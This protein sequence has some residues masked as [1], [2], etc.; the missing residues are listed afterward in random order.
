MTKRTDIHSTGKINPADYLNIGWDYVGPDALEMMGFRG[1]RD[2][3]KKVMA[4]NNWTWSL[5]T[6]G[7][8]CGICGAL[9]HYLGIFVHTHTGEVIRVGSTCSEKMELEDLGVFKAARA[10]I[11]LGREFMAGK[12]RLAQALGEYG[13]TDLGDWFDHEN[14][15]RVAGLRDGKP[16][17]PASMYQYID[18]QDVTPERLLELNQ[19]EDAFRKGEAAWFR[20]QR[21]AYGKAF[22]DILWAEETLNDMLHK[23]A[24]YG[25]WSEKQIPFAKK[26]WGRISNWKTWATD[27]KAKHEA[28]VAEAA[29][30]PE[31]RAV[32]TGTVL[33][34][35]VRDNAYGIV[36]KL[37][38][39]DDSGWKG[40]VTCP[41]NIPGD[42]GSRVTLTANWTPSDDD[43][44]FAWGKRPSK[45]EELEAAPQDE[46]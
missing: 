15:G 14:G 6:H 25:D 11:A 8:N 1:E 12:K 9:S 10:A 32:I 20:T 16:E 45:A 17:A 34:Y 5:H 46:N 44:K 2:Q 41:S 38:V 31:G 29:D 19:I 7:G 42:K 3:I 35:N 37:L 36:V 22:N 13:M 18:P 33:S 23:L 39:K 4:K 28:D 24:K 40:W 27:R 30:A 43:K 21:A 26:L